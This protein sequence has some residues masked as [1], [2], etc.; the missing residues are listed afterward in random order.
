MPALWELTRMVHFLLRPR[1]VLTPGLCRSAV[2]EYNSRTIYICSGL[3]RRYFDRTVT[4]NWRLAGLTPPSLSR[5]Y[6]VKIDDYTVIGATLL[7]EVT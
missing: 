2:T 6:T 7:H 5:S 3:W 4:P 1:Y